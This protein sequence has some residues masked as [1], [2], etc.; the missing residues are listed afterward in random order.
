MEKD[1]GMKYPET[2]NHPRYKKVLLDFIRETVTKKLEAQMDSITHSIRD[3]NNVKLT[4]NVSVE[5]DESSMDLIR[6]FMNDEVPPVG[7]L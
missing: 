4:L 5:L 1:P 2:E 7:T 3:P 6:A